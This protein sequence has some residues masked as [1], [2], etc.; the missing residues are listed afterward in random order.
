MGASG[1][2]MTD[3][4]EGRAVEEVVKLVEGAGRLRPRCEN[5]AVRHEEGEVGE[6]SN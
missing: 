2:V 3:A 4:C 6:A 1:Q 5:V